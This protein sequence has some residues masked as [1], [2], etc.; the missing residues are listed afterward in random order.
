MFFS[1][2]PN[3]IMTWIGKIINPIFLVFLAVLIISALIHP[4]TEVSGVLPADGYQDG[5]LFSSL[6][7]V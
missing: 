6:I 2:R 4:G 5:A 1:L 7:E 3:G